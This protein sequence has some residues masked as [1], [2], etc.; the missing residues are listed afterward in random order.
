LLH[1]WLDG[2]DFMKFELLG[3]FDGEARVAAEDDVDY[4]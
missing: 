3:L 2:Q 1:G 4:V